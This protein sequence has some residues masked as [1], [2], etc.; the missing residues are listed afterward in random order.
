[1]LQLDFM[2]DL[3]KVKKYHFANPCAY[4]AAETKITQ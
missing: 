1:M 4:Y 2:Q 3:P